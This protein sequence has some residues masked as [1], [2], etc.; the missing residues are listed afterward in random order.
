[1]LEP[2]V[3]TNSEI[4]SVIQ[5][6]YHIKVRGIRKI[7]EGSANI[8]IINNN[9]YVLKEFPSWYTK[10]NINKEARII[11]HLQK[12]GIPVANYIKTINNDYSFLYKNRVVILQKFIEGKTLKLNTATEQQ[13][14][15]SM[16]YLGKIIKSLESLDFNLEVNNIISPEIITENI[17]KLKKLLLQTS[18]KEY[19]HIYKDLQIK[20]TI[21]EDMQN[22]L[23]FKDLNHL[24][25]MNT[26]GDYN[27]LQFIYK[28][29]QINAILDFA[30]A[31]KMPIVWEIIRSYSY[32][33]K[34]AKN[35]TIDI[36]NLI[37]CLQKINKYIKL[38][39]YDLEYMPIIYMLQLAGSSFGYKEYLK[40]NS[41]Q[42]LLTFA[43]F[44][45]NL[46]RYLY[47]NKEIISN[48]LKNEILS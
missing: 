16:E 6:E 34:K 45:T 35:G 4:I 7:N 25:I 18:K 27:I 41:K 21:L 29:N 1:M 43:Y 38:N 10:D 5:E 48:A 23:N 47:T 15:E 3:F 20:L 13:M 24:T 33:D 28:N 37:K 9:Q 22:N 42:E 8:Y 17:L 44:R 31:T 11:T 32:I 19:S 26:H 30:S 12:D 40:D 2:S 14:F 36:N 46:C 39:S